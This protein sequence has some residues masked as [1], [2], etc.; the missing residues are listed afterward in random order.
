MFSHVRCYRF[1]THQYTQSENAS[2]GRVF[3][4][5]VVA[6]SNLHLASNRRR[7]ELKLLKTHPLGVTL[8]VPHK[9]LSKKICLFW[10]EGLP[11]S[12]QIVDSL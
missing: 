8:I 1:A 2:G 6:A 7:R 9:S 11:R 5:S 12:G 4:I 3:K 10:A